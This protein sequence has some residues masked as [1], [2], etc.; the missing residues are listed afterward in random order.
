[1]DSTEDRAN[2]LREMKVCRFCLSDKKSQLSNIHEKHPSES[3]HSIPLAIQIMACMTIEVFKNDGMP[4]LICNTCRNLTQQAYIFKT[5]CK[6]SDEALKLFLATGQLSKPYLQKVE[7]LTLPPSQPI[8]LNPL[9]TP[10]KSSKEPKSTKKEGQIK[11]IKI[12]A[13]EVITVDVTE[14]E[15]AE[16]IEQGQHENEEIFGIVEHEEPEAG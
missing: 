11:Q 12:E 15:D 9:T 1:M 4:Q 6:K 14:D 10:E 2:I 5:N 8:I 7:Q 3:K 16:M 13:G